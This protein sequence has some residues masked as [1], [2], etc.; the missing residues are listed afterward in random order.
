MIAIRILSLVGLV[1]MGLAI[2]W[3]AATGD[4]GAEGSAIWALP[5]GKVS[6]IDIYVGLAFFGAWIAFREESLWKVL[7]WWAGLVV[8]GNF[9]AALYLAIASFTSDRPK[10]LLAGES[11]VSD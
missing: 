10:E 7:L 5:W 3:A 6:L 1:A 2:V 11:D 4:F 9:T 8:L